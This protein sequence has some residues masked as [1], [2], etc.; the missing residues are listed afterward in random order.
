MCSP[1]IRTLIAHV[2]APVLVGAMVYLLWRSPKL[3]MFSWVRAGGLSNLLAVCR[4]TTSPVVP[5]LPGWF[6]YS[7]PDGLW[8]YSF[9]S[10]ILAVW[11]GTPRP[12]GKMAWA[13]TP[14]LLGVGAEVLQW[15]RLIPGVFDPA[16]V[17][18]C[19]LGGTAAIVWWHRFA[20]LGCGRAG[21]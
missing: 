6:L 18:A 1:R 5:F 2:L 19:I 13:L 12:S 17:T 8:V 10:F 20:R 14:A 15:F 21:G 7:F 11:C 16:D 3:L 9:T 4:A